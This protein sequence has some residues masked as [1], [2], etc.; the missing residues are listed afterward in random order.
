MEV[1]MPHFSEAMSGNLSYPAGPTGIEE[2]FDGGQTFSRIP[3]MEG[4]EF[5]DG[6]NPLVR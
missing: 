6:T 3:V 4:A 5:I 1:E 2:E